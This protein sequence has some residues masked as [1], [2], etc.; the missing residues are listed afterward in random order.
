MTLTQES[1]T[2]MTLTVHHKHGEL[3]IK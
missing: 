1:R 3:Y 2:I